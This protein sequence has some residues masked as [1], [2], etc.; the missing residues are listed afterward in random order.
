MQFRDVR[1]RLTT[2]LA[3]A[4]AVALLAACHTVGGTMSGMGQDIGATGRVLTGN[5]ANPPPPG[6]AAPGNQG[7]APG[8]AAAPRY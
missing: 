5:P 2:A 3:L 1:G 6:T 8:P 7:Q 4:A